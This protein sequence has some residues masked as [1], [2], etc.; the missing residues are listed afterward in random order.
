MKPMITA[1]KDFIS[2]DVRLTHAAKPYFARMA[3]KP[4]GKLEERYPQTVFLLFEIALKYAAHHHD[5]SLAENVDASKMIDLLQQE[6]KQLMSKKAPEIID[7]EGLKPNISKV[8]LDGLWQLFHNYVVNL[9]IPSY[10]TVDLLL[11]KGKLEMAHEEALKLTHDYDK[12]KSIIKLT[13]YYLNQ[14]NH[15]K[16][17][18]LFALM[19]EG[20]DRRDLVTK[21]IHSLLSEQQF[22]QALSFSKD[23]INH[24]L[25]EHALHEISLWL[26]KNGRLE[27]SFIILNEMIDDEMK[28]YTLSLIVMILS[29]QAKFTEASKLAFSIR[30]KDYRQDGINDIVKKMVRFRRMP[31]AEEFAAQ[32]DEAVEKREARKIIESSLKSRLQDERIKRL[33]LA[34][35]PIRATATAFSK[36]RSLGVP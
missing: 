12:T 18:A 25:S 27:D 29:G 7:N 28:A 5:D 14:K 22:D 11:E 17:I 20:N 23:L 36:N 8:D 33:H 15:E 13:I 32:L 34:P 24:E 21:I 6:A 1:S 16:A 35:P 4:I 3:E 30:D 10:V 2:A 31:E 9:Q 19:P 26:A